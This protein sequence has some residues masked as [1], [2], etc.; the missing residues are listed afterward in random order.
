MSGARRRHT[1][2]WLVRNAEGLRSPLLLAALA[3]IISQLLGVVLLVVMAD[4]VVTAA[5]GEEVRVGALAGVLVGASLIKAGLRY[6]EHYAGHWVAFTALQRLR[7]LFFAALVPQAPA[8]TR[9]RAGAALTET[10]TRDIDRIE[11][12]FAHTFPPA[13]SAVLT[14]AIA[15]IWLD[16]AVESSA[17]LLLMPFVLAVL[18][19]PLVS[20]GTVWTSARRVASDRSAVAARVGDDVHGVRDVLMLGAEERRLTALDAAGDGLTRA[21]SAS[22]S[23]QGARTAIIDLLQ[24]TAVLVIVGAGAVTGQELRDVAVALAVAV[25]L[26]GPVRGI[27]SFMAGLDAALASAQRLRAVVDAPPTV[28]DPREPSQVLLEEV[29]TAPDVEF[30]GVTLRYALTDSSSDPAASG[31]GASGAAVRTA[32]ED[33]S[34]VFPGGEWSFVVGVSGSGKSSM[35][36]LLLRAWDPETGEVRLGG[37]TVAGLPLDVLRSRVAL[38]DQRPTL[39][40]DT[41]LRNLILAA[42]EATAEQVRTALDVVG[43]ADWVDGL[44]RALDTVLVSGRTEVSG[45]Q[46]QRLA[47]ARALLARPQVLVLD[48]A[49]SQLDEATATSVRGRLAAARPGLTTLEITHRVDLVPDAAFVAVIDAGRLVEQGRAAELR[50]EAGAFSRLLER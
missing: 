38:V 27:D 28:T 22:G 8:A 13:V 50:A 31:D 15:L 42:P 29:P 25:G 49:L 33:V 3:R 12:F 19:V 26:R 36:S 10:A 9:G 40:A 20:A 45:G 43:L 46:L 32:L 7:E 1:A 14:P 37:A 34:V 23:V 39:L 5:A 17:A 47:L 21:R 4:A 2:G 35:A 48:E 44:P 16:S 11:V 30:C 24:A 41:V 18:V 6:A